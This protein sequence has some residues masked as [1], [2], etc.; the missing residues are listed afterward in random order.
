MQPF[1]AKVDTP[2]AMAEDCG[3]DELLW[4]IA[5]ANVI[6]GPVGVPVQT[7]PNL[8]SLDDAQVMSPISI[9]VGRAWGDARVM[10]PRF[11]FPRRFSEVQV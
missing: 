10:S 5:A 6:L 3:L 4:T 2:M 7:P 1:R 11:F 9:S 8:S